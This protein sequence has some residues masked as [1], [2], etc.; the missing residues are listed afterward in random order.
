MFHMAVPCIV[1]NLNL[2]KK[3]E[4]FFNTGPY[5]EWQIQKATPASVMKFFQANFYLNVLQDSPRKS[6]LLPF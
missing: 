6:H 1:S 3:N 4:I 5:M 2:K